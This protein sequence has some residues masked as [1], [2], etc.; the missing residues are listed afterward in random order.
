MTVEL[1]YNAA[2]GETYERPYVPSPELPAQPAIPHIVTALQARTALRRA[3]LL[4]LAESAVETLGDEAKDAWEY[5]I[6][7]ARTSP[8][9]N[10]LATVLGLS[11]EDV[12]TLFIEAA[13]IEF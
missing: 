13:G 12:D 2:T 6:E 9:I 5:S 8:M 4:V 10:Q 1:V 3:G 11:S 7:W